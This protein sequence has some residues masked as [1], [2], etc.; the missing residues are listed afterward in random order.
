[1]RIVH[2]ERSEGSLCLTDF[3]QLTNCPPRANH[4]AS[5]CF[6]SLPNCPICK[7]FV[8]TFIQHAGVCVPPVTFLALFLANL[9]LYFQQLPGCS[10]RNP[11]PINLLHCCRGCVPP[12]LHFFL[13]QF[14]KTGTLPLAWKRRSAR[15]TGTSASP[16]ASR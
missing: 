8:L 13:F 7:S 11:F 9:H 10:S 1:M 12:C 3:Q 2:P 5:L 14:Q 15:F 6:Q 4:L 16:C